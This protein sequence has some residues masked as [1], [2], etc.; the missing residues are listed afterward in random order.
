MFDRASA[1]LVGIAHPLCHFDLHI[2]RKLI[3]GAAR[4][5]MQMAADRPEELFGGT[6]CVVFFLPEYIERTSSAPSLAWCRYFAIQ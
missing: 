4:D 1:C 6:E 5:E 3:G 2:E